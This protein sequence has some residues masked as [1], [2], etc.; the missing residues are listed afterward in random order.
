MLRFEARWFIDV[1]KSI[2]GMNPTLLELAELDFNMVEAAYQ[3]DLKQ[4]SR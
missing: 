1:Y 4:V 3:E 2:E